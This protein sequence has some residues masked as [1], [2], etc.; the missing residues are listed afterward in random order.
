MG[1]VY[2]CSTG[3]AVPTAR[4]Y[5]GIHANFA[6]D[7]ILVTGYDL[8]CPFIAPILQL[9]DESSDLR[10]ADRGM[11]YLPQHTLAS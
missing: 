3:H 5:R 1:E 4:H 7:P 2:F 9:A 6:N 8:L 11:A 10:V